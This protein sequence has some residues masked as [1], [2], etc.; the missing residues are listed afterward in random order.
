MHVESG[1][2]DEAVSGACCREGGGWDT[3]GETLP[4]S[5]EGGHICLFSIDH[6]LHFY[7]YLEDFECVKWTHINI[8]S[9]KNTKF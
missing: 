7:I 5:L 3:V 6:I 2:R 9:S 1:Y 4:P 8:T